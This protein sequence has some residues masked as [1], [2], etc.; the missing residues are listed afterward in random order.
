M[1]ETFSNGG[2]AA[3]SA[4]VDN[5]VT[6]LPVT[7]NTG[8]PTSANF[9]IRVDSEIMLVTS[10]G[11]S[12]GSWTVTRGVESTTAASHST[13]AIVTQVLTAGALGTLLPSDTPTVTSSLTFSNSANVVFGTGGGTKIGTSTAQKLSFYNAATTTQPANA[14]Q[15]ALI[16]DVGTPSGT[17]HLVDVTGTP[18]QTTINDN[19]ATVATLINQIRADLVTLG[20]I[21]G[22][23]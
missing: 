21:K 6:T 11:Q 23:A 16:P 9:R 3:L 13:G 17:F 5:S 22:S 20:L 4:G 18:T 12:S 7:S 19:F 10:G 2:T 15:A 14:N 1:S 8:L